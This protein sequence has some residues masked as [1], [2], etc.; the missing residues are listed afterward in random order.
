AESR[1]LRATHPRRAPRRPATVPTP[2]GG[3]ALLADPR[4]HRGVLG[5]AGPARAISSGDVG[6]ASSGSHHGGRW[7]ELEAAMRVDLP[8]TTVSA[9][10]RELVRLR[11][12][13]GAVALG[14]VLT[15]II[16]TTATAA[17]SAIA[18]PNAASREHPM[19]VLVLTEPD[20]GLGGD[21]R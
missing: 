12:E 1:G 11:E 5:R 17:E 4:P 21:A 9:I 8:G 16:V 13:G 14:R 3:R 7:P 6:P 2:R 18:A 10:S 15:L 19:R 20:D